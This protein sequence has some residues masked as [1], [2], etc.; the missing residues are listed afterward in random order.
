[1]AGLGKSA[2]CPSSPCDAVAEVHNGEDNN[3]GAVSPEHAPGHF[4]EGRP[5]PA[6]K[7]RMRKRNREITVLAP[8]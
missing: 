7:K 5:G 1:M 6:I 4:L 2:R 3:G 8:L